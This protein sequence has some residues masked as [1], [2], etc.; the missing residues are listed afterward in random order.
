MATKTR[1]QLANQ[2]DD[3]CD[4]AG[5]SDKIRKLHTSQF[6]DKKWNP[7][8]SR[9]FIDWWGSVGAEATERR[10]DRSWVGIDAVRAFNSEAVREVYSEAKQVG[11]V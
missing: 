9:R 7:H 5:C 4:Q 8:P 11:I 2:I 6:V 10:T 3:L 1:Q